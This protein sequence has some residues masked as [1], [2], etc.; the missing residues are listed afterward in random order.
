MNASLQLC[1]KSDII[2]CASHFSLCRFRP[3]IPVSHVSDTL[4]FPS[5]DECTA[6]LAE[7]GLPLSG[8]SP[9]A[10]DC[11]A[12]LSVLQAKATAS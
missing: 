7:L 3:S 9:V 11:K 12:C 10:L 4:A 8:P 2:P 5:N 6:W 1:G